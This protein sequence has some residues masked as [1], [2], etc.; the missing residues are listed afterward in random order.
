MESVTLFV[1]PVSDPMFK[2][3]LELASVDL[4]S[5]TGELALSIEFA[6][7][8]VALIFVAIFELFNSNSIF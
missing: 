1:F 8:V 5:S 2:P 6:V 4:A 3:V 7:E